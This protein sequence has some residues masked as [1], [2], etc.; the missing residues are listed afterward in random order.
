MQIHEPRMVP[1]DLLR[2][3]P[4]NPKKPMGGKYRRGLLAAIRAHGFAGVLVVA[5]N[6]D[7]TYLVLDGNSRR[8]LM[9]EEGV[10][11]APCI[12]PPEFREGAEDWEAK[13]KEF[14]LAHDRHRKLFDEDM[15]ADQLKELAA[16][17]R[18]V[19]RLAVLSGQDKLKRLLATQAAP[20]ADG[21]TSKAK[22]PPAMAS[23]VLY[24]PA[25]DV[26][27]IKELL[28]QCKEKLLAS[29]ARAV[30][31]QAVEFLDWTDE[32]LLAC[33]LAAVARFGK[34]SA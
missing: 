27:E 16:K 29:K 7:G 12:V 25:A 32:R 11:E 23:L 17:G 2:P 21:S 3:N 20:A 1:L 30:L 6:A 31:G 33:L 4:D 14:T 19:A 13:R 5:E 8:D 9:D 10:K 24:G 22:A 18:E 28:K 15:V 34:E 26:A